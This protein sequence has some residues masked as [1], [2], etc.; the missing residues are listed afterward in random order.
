MIFPIGDDNVEGGAK[1][2]FTYLFMAMNV[3]IFF[4]QMSLGSMEAIQ[5][6]VTTFG[7]IPAEIMN[8]QDLFTLGTSIFLHGGL[9]HLLGN[10][11]YLWI[12]SDNIEATA[13]NFHFLIFYFLGGLFASMAHILLSPGSTIPT[14]GAS[15]AISA[16]MGAYIVCFP[17]S[18]I[19]MIILIL[20]RKFHIPAM[21]FLGFWFAQQIFSSFSGDGSQGGVAWWAHI[22][23]FIFGAVY[24]LLFFKK[25]PKTKYDLEERPLFV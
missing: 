2:Y 19:K 6:F 18:R 11:L 16:I 22:G 13:G 14:V 7:A 17:K 9:M 1:P 24:G 4:F 20:F 5:S 10:M 3:L 15:G 23:G 25:N 21:L 8:M 12:F